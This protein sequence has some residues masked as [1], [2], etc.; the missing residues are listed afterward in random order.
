M[1]A[2][3]YR[4]WRSLWAL[5][6]FAFLAA[7]QAVA[8][9]TTDKSDMNGDGIVDQ[10]DLEIFASLHF[11]EDFDSID[12]CAFYESSMLNEKYF[13]RVVG[14][15]IEYYEALLSYIASAYGCEVIQ[16][17]ADK[18]DL[19]DDGVLQADEY[20]NLY[21]PASSPNSLALTDSLAVS[22]FR[23]SQTKLT[24]YTF[25]IGKDLLQMRTGILSAVFGLERHRL[26]EIVPGR[27]PCRRELS[28]GLARQ[29]LEDEPTVV[30]ATFDLEEIR[31]QRAAWGLFRD[32]RPDLY[33]SLLTLDGRMARG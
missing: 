2:M 29:H 33:A 18:S 27:N 30:T 22:T 10:Q 1:S 23:R 6:V 15:R 17:E 26:D 14:D 12:W 4:N 31:A 11:E 28:V 32:R 25:K 20:W 24:S 13:R 3:N 9:P 5:V 8:A 21:S 7:G 19:N 16:P